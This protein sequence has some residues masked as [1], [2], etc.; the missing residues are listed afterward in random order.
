MQVVNVTPVVSMAS[1]S[2]TAHGGVGTLAQ[3]KSPKQSA[4]ASIAAKIFKAFS[5]E[6]CLSV[7][8]FSL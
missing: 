3:E 2:V 6:L 4:V 8:C 5:I 1:V 7:F